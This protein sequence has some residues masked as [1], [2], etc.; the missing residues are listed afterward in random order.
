MALLTWYF[1]LADLPRCRS[2][3]ASQLTPRF[4]SHGRSG[5][6]NIIRMTTRDEGRAEETIAAWPTYADMASTRVFI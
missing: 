1:W 6:E 4:S 2:H 5:V 3:H